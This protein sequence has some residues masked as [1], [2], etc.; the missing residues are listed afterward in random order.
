MTESRQ[1]KTTS[2]SVAAEIAEATT[3]EEESAA[4]EDMVRGKIGAMGGA[5]ARA[6]M[7]D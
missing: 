3:V 5:K 4:S 2:E 1:L 6:G 7:V